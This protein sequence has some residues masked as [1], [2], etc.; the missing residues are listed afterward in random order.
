MRPRSSVPLHAVL[1][2]SLLF[3]CFVTF[4][5]AAAVPSAADIQT[6]QIGEHALHILSPDLL[7]L[8]LVNTKQPDPANMNLW[9]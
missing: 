4:N 9:D 7:E 6:P 5:A 8:F 3:G 2:G 1:R